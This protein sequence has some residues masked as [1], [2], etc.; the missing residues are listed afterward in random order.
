MTDDR[1]R[2]VS[3]ALTEIRTVHSRALSALHRLDSEWCGDSWWD[4][5]PW[6]GQGG[7]EG[8][9]AWYDAHHINYVDPD[10]DEMYD[11]LETVAE[12]LERWEKRGRRR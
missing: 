1:S 4:G 12:L 6:D 7:N 5:V 3:A 10:Y 11:A 9:T 2:D 8:H